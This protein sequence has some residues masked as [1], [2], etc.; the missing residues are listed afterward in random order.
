M[1]GHG[2]YV[3]ELVVVPRRRRDRRTRCIGRLAR[4][5]PWSTGVPRWSR[6]LYTD[7]N[8]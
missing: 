4:L 8:L 3:N 6:E 1:D 2:W 5:N 7:L